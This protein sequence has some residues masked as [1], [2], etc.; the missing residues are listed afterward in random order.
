[1]NEVVEIKDFQLV[2]NQLLHGTVLPGL[3]MR[4]VQ[5]TLQPEIH[6]IDIH[7]NGNFIV[8]NGRVG[9]TYFR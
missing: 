3:Q 5:I 2:G 1:M 8:G 9:D 4:T 6:K 7:L